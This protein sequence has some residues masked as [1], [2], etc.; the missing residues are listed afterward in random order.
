M[1][2]HPAIAAGRAAV[3]TGA[4]GGIGLAAAKRFA[5]L[6]MKV[7]LA[8]LPGVIAGCWAMDA[9]PWFAGRIIGAPAPRPRLDGARVA[10]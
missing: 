8:D 1:A 4:A 10:G 6:G 3:I 5:G 2:Q 9:P 7:V